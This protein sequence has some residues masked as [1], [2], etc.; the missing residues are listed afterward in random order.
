MLSALA[1]EMG[2][3][4]RK[5]ALNGQRL[6][7]VTTRL[8]D[9]ERE[10][11]DAVQSAE[12][13]LKGLTGTKGPAGQNVLLIRPQEAVASVQA[14]AQAYADYYAAVADYDRAQFRLY[15]A[16]GRPAQGLTCDPVV[17]PG[18]APAAPPTLPP[19]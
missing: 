3:F 19:G 1:G 14:L 12:D 7:A 8:G 16:L 2:V 4:L 10:V 13:N 5:A 9:A 6:L 15:R 11:K 18:T 17:V